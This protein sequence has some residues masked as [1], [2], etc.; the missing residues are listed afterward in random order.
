MR[1]SSQTVEFEAISPFESNFPRIL[2]IR[3]RFYSKHSS[4]LIKELYRDSKRAPALPL[5]QFCLLNRDRGSPERLSL[6]KLPSQEPL[7]V[8]SYLDPFDDNFGHSKRSKLTLNLDTVYESA[9]QWDEK[10][11]S[12]QSITASAV[13]SPI[14]HRRRL[15]HKERR[16]RLIRKKMREYSRETIVKKRQMRKAFRTIPL[17]LRFPSPGHKVVFISVS[18]FDESFPNGALSKILNKKKTMRHIVIE[19]KTDSATPKLSLPRPDAAP[20]PALTPIAAQS[21]A[22]RGFFGDQSPRMMDELAV[23]QTTALANYRVYTN[24]SGLY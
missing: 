10:L 19:T 7:N 8:P 16:A 4:L 17:G 20:F 5:D 13:G 2:E 22:K 11:F 18:P 9:D 24:T 1:C 23:V 14:R 6:R 21:F 15:S 12:K 3:T